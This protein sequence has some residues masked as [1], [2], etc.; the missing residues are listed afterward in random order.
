[1]LYNL[2]KDTGLEKLKNTKRTTKII[3]VNRKSLKGHVWDQ[4]S[5]TALTLALNLRLDRDDPDLWH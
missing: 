5:E 3:M 2:Q 4:D 1:M